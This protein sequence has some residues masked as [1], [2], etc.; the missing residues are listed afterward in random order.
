MTDHIARLEE[1][2]RDAAARE[3]LA[4]RS[5]PDRT[6]PS[7][8]VS[9]WGPQFG[10]RGRSR[11]RLSA[12]A[13]VLGVALLAGSAAAAVLALV[14]SS[15]PVSGT[16]PVTVIPNH[17]PR[18]GSTP[19]SSPIPPPSSSQMRPLRLH[20]DVPLIP[21]L[22]PG[23]AGWCSYP[24]FA[25]A[26]LIDDAGGGTCSPAPPPG[27][28]VLVSGGEPISNEQS[29]IA[30]AGYRISPRQAH[31]TLVWMFVSSR[32]A[33]VRIDASQLIA[34]RLDPLAPS[35]E[36]ALVVFT[37]VAPNDIR[38]VLIDG[39]GQIITDS[40]PNGRSAT[41]G[42]VPVRSVSPG[43]RSS[44]PCS[45]ARV[46]LPAVTA[47]WEV[48]VTRTK[49]LG[50][51]VSRDTLSSCART[52]F[53]IRGQTTAPSATILLN[54]QDPARPAPM[55]PGLQPTRQPGI[56]ANPSAEL[57]AKRVGR[58]WLVVQ[59]QSVALADQLLKAARVQ[60]TAP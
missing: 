49:G 17:S 33:Q 53:A 25:I 12:V 44:G 19:G 58:A 59:C 10:R 28:T 50:A 46:H 4:G 8:D 38:P 15:A 14:G 22:E 54:A 37:S 36:K 51:A 55:P 27:S 20:Y 2:L 45:I 48:A 57:R 3:Y 60:G 18:P 41:N 47:Q 13:L 1:S 24:S 35:G 21:D 6:E 39:H 52:W 7:V 42:V 34:P 26:G 29:L 32:V 9:Q 40:N 30:A 43:S 23:N 5:A 56:Y 31:M 16:V 11:L